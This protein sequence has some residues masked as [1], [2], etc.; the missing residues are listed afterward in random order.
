VQAGFQAQ[1][2]GDTAGAEAAYQQ[3][4]S[5]QP[6]HPAALQLLGGL[7][8]QRGENVPAEA[9]LR[10]SLAADARQ[11]RVWHKR[12]PGGDGRLGLAHEK[13][14]RRPLVCE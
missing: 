12:Q 1:Q 13:G 4:L 8:R 7:A 5:L 9:L 3:A 2:Q 14:A 11:P 6:E 10:R